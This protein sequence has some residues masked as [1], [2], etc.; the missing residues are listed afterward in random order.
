MI[1]LMESEL[2]VSVSVEVTDSVGGVFFLELS[3]AILSQVLAD[4]P[5]VEVAD[6]ISVDSLEACVRLK[7]RHER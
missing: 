3:V 5:T 4:L 1:L 2:H 7:L 6:A